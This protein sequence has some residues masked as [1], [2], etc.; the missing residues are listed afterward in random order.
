[1]LEKETENAIMEFLWWNKIYSWRNNNTPIFDP[2]RKLFRKM[3]KWGLKGTS[4]IL[5]ILKDGRFLAIEVKSAKGVVSQEQK[6]F[7]KNINDNGGKAFVAR[8][9]DDVRKELEI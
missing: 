1:M 3:P 4:D 9:I 7:I 5:G 2:E 8:S 6:D